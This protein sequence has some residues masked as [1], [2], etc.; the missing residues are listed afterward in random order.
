MNDVSVELEQDLLQ[1]RPQTSGEGARLMHNDDTVEIN[2]T[3]QKGKLSH[4]KLDC[5]VPD[6][7]MGHRTL[8]PLPLE[9]GVGD[10][11]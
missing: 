6:T 2:C 7:L 11:L 4:Q 8:S 1:R 9:L 3:V 5:M 10:A